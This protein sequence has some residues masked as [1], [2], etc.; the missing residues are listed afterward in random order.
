MLKQSPAVIALLLIMVAGRGMVA[1][2][3]YFAPVLAMDIYGFNFLPSDPVW[4]FI[5]VWAG[6][7]IILSLLVLTS[8][9]NYLVPLL[10]ACL[11]VEASDIVAASLGYASGA[12]DLSHFQAQ[13]ATILAPAMI[14]EGIALY[15]II[16]RPGSPVANRA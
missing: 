6:R 12:L 14:P 13:L 16:R 8:R 15:L 11:G 2:L 10:I 4:Y 3:S 7:D 5:R 9:P 1:A